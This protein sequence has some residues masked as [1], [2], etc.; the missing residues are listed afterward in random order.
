MQLRWIASSGYFARW[1]LCKGRRLSPYSDI[2]LLRFASAPLPTTGSRLWQNRLV[3]VSDAD[4]KMVEA[5][6]TDPE[7][8]VEVIGGLRQAR[9]LLDKNGTAEV[10]LERARAIHLDT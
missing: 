7:K 1:Q 9:I 5:W 8:V 2:D 6:F 4:T 10:L 3:S